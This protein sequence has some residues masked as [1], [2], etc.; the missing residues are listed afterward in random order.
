MH[1]KDKLSLSRYSKGKV[2]QTDRH[3]AESITTVGKDM[4]E[5]GV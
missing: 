2:L 5:R 1:T 3:A 4:C